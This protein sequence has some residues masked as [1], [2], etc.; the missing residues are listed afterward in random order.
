MLTASLWLVG[1]AVAAG[2]GLSCFYLLERPIR[3]AARLASWAH[4]LVGAAGTALAVTAAFPAA[5]PGGFGRLSVYGLGATL[6]AGVAIFVAQ[7][8]RRR[9]P[10]LVVVLHATLGMAAFI[11]LLAY[12]ATAGA[13]PR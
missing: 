10:G 6:L 11:I 4:G 12:A 5:D 13:G 7:L 2:L 1:A 3:G 8:R 9:P